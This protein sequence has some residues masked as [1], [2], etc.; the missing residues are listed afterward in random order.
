MMD[1]GLNLLIPIQVQ[2]WYETQFKLRDFGDLVPLDPHSE[3]RSVKSCL[4][5]RK[6]GTGLSSILLY[7]NVVIK[8]LEMTISIFDWHYSLS[9]ANDQKK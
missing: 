7:N 4:V 2:G 6:M 5:S 8:L 9:A 1:V 3:L